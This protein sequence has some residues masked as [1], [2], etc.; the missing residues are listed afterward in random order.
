VKEERGDVQEMLIASEAFSA[1]EV[2]VALEILT[3]GIEG[4]PDADY[5][6]FGAEI[7]G[8]LCGYA[9]IGQTPLTLSTWHL[10]WICVHPEF[11]GRG[12]GQVLLAEVECF[13][14]FRGGK[15]IVVET[16]GR[17]SYSR[18]RRFYE[19]GGYQLRGRI[20]DYYKP[21]DDCLYYNK[22]I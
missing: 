22:E 7:N 9:C 17:E 12:V 4:G 1:E 11:Q 5:P 13:I 19:A 15:R 2:R 8:K 18:T 20:P 21:A 14:R 6:A 3:E 16:S 10:Y